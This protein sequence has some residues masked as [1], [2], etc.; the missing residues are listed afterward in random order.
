MEWNEIQPNV[1]KPTTT[2]EAIEGV[3]IDK[4]LDKG[5]FGSSA[6][7]I[8]S[9]SGQTLVWGSA[10][11]DERMKYINIGDLVRIEYKGTQ[12][13]KRGQDVKIFKV[14]KGGT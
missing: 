14:F 3:L 10:V 13:N 5:S 11:L 6:Y 1:W 12:K 4:Q 9:Q 2:G 8:E 7:A